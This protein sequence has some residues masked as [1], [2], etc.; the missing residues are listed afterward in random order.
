[1]SEMARRVE[2]R[3]LEAAGDYEIQYYIRGKGWK[4]THRTSRSTG[5]EESSPWA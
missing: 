4:A 5:R 1:M 2:A 3:Y